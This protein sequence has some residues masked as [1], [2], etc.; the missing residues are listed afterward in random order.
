M[1]PDRLRRGWG[2]ALVA[3]LAAVSL[4]AVANE[5]DTSQSRAGFSLQ[6]RWGQRVEG[7]FPTLHGV[8]DDLGD[9]R[10]RV[11]L[12]LY[13][14]D[15]EILGHPGYTRSTRGSG[16]FDAAHWP[17]VEFLSDPYWP[18]LLRD[19]GQLGGILGM[20][21]VQHRET[22]Q[23]L[24]AACHRPGEDCD[25][26]AVGRVARGN[27]GMDRWRVAVGEE[28]RFNLHLRIHPETLR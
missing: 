6:T 27:Y 14:A 8:I 13:T 3:A 7:R 5:I 19:G 1:T 20:R 10:H 2:V 18:V 23:V 21:G 28:V 12:I 15:V 4:V 22:F 16:F 17:Q 9:G 11:R 24:P 26:V 25:V